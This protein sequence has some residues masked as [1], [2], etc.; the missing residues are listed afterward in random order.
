MIIVPE[1]KP[2]WGSNNKV[3]MYVCTIFFSLI[4]PHLQYCVSVWGSAYPTNYS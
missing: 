4:H 2:L 1:N 3:Y